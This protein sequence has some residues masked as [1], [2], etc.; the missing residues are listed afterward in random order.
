M[1]AHSFNILDPGDAADR[2]MISIWYFPQGIRSQALTLS[3]VI[4]MMTM[5]L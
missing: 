3:L 2:K 4:V 5:T 1:S